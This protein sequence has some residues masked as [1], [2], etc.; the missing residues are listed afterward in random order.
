MACSLDLSGLIAT[1]K[2]GSQV[3]LKLVADQSKIQRASLNHSDITEDI[4]ADGK[5]LSFPVPAGRNTLILVL[6]PPPTGED[7]DLVEDCGG[8]TTQTVLSFGIGIHVSISF[9]IVA[10]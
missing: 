4:A 3:T 7:V 6:L 10:S 9:D 5:S 8:G 2:A 1:T